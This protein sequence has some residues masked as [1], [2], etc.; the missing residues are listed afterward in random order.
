MSVF[1]CPNCGRPLTGE[2]R[3]LVCPA[4]HSFDKAKSGYVNLLL[5]QQT[6]QKHHGDDKLMVKARS[7]FLERGYYDPMRQELIR[8]GLAAARQ[9]MT[10]LD[11]GCG[12]G[13]YTAELA[14]RLRE[15]GF[16]PK[17][18][19]I[20]ISKA[21]L[22][23]A[24]WRDKETEYA[25]ASCFHL[26]TAGE[27]VDLQLSVFAPYCGEEF[28]RV[29]RPAGQF[30]MVIPLENHLYGLKE[31][32]YEKPYRNE[33][34]PYE[35]AGFALEECRELRYEITLRG[36]EEIESLFMMTPYYYKT[37][38]ADQQKLREKAELTTPVEF[39][40][41]RYRKL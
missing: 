21:A 15:A 39:A 29:L 8:Q 4:G 1:C 24:A 28:Q 30:I 35:L 32:I 23:E 9:G 31:A 27:S 5:S 17:M 2:E 19:G 41:L 37:G 22:Q 14:R 36:Q 25:V 3:R 38:A 20:D 12:E 16:Q 7:A 11:A 26:P 33:V 13:Y 40:V 10:V 6:G 18:A 34:K